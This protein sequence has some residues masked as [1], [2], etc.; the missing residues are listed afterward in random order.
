MTCTYP[1][2]DLC[3][4]QKDCKLQYGNKFTSQL[5]KDIAYYQQLLEKLYNQLS[6]YWQ[7]VDEIKQG[8]YKNKVNVFGNPILT[9]SDVYYN[10]N[11]ELI[12]KNIE[13]TKNTINNLTR[14]ENKVIKTLKRSKRRHR[15]YGI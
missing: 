1:Q 7:T 12:E 13:V 9:P 15:I 11:I 4:Y 6:L 8:V 2:H 10:L 14:E 3:K 5:S